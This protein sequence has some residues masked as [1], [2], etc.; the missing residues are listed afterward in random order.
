MLICFIW[1]L[2]NLDSPLLKKYYQQLSPF[3]FEKLILI[4]SACLDEFEYIYESQ[5][6]DKKLVDS[7]TAQNL[8]KMAETI[9]GEGSAA[10][11]LR[12][13]RFDTMAGMNRV[14]EPNSMPEMRS[15]SSSTSALGAAKRSSKI[16]Q[17]RMQLLNQA[18]KTNLTIVENQSDMSSIK[19]LHPA[20][21]AEIS[22]VI[23]KSVV[24]NILFERD[25]YQ[26]EKVLLNILIKILSLRQCNEIYHITLKFIR[27]FPDPD[28]NTR[29]FEVLFKLGINPNIAEIVKSDVART[30]LNC[31]ENGSERVGVHL[32]ITMSEMIG[33]DEIDSYRLRTVLKTIFEYIDC[34]MKYEMLTRLTDPTILQSTVQQTDPAKGSNS[35]SNSR[36]LEIIQLIKELDDI[37]VSHLKLKNSNDPDLKITLLHKIAQSCNRL[38]VL[39][40]KWLI[41]TSDKHKEYGQFL[42]AAVCLIHIAGIILECLDINCDELL[43]LSPNILEES[44]LEEQRISVK[45]SK[46]CEPEWLRVR[47]ISVLYKINGFIWFFDKKI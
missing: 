22:R 43:D 10:S 16:L 46:D 44:L 45:V 13:R 15:N 23:L 26:N 12:N 39:R 30:I 32:L 18:R 27:E 9:L 37:I 24:N 7:K 47:R 28:L 31:L 1:T 4:C 42:E 38:P 21:T 25:I 11:K 29:A 2:K 20:I 40:I 14:S 5:Q 19:L 17:Q 35:S 33:R 8:S 6:Q 36:N 34:D 41:R 3:E